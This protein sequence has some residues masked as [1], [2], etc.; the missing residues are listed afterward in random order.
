MINSSPYEKEALKRY[1]KQFEFPFEDDLDGG[2]FKKRVLRS[3]FQA[4][5]VFSAD[6]GDVLKRSYIR[7]DPFKLGYVLY[8]VMHE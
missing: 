6:K 4:E 5:E 1:A 8:R 2:R 3:D 7:H